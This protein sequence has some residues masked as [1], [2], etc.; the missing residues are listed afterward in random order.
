MIQVFRALHQFPNVSGAKIMANKTKLF[1]KIWQISL[2]DVQL[3]CYK[4]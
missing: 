4:F 2:V 1:A 3:F